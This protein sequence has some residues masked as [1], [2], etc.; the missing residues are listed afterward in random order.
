MH[1]NTDVKLDHRLKLFCRRW[2]WWCTPLILAFRKQRQVDFWVWGQPGLQSEFQDSQGY[3][4]KPCLEK[5][6]P[7]QTKPNQNKTSS[8]ET[9]PSDKPTRGLE[10][11]CAGFLPSCSWSSSLGRHASPPG[12]CL[13]HRQAGFLPCLLRVFSKSRS[14]TLPLGGS[15]TMAV[16]ISLGFLQLLRT[17]PGLICC[18]T[19][20][21]ICFQL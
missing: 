8:A 18:R 7:N 17:I 9:I 15:V 21:R 20:L 13:R 4:E 5:P 12:A 19:F 3:T 14:S 2:A 11:T 1:M 6:K 16:T 10:C